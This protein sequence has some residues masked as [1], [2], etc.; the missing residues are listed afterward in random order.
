MPYFFK[1]PKKVRNLEPSFWGSSGVVT[2]GGVD[3]D[4][5]P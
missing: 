3:D 4:M 5:V 1:M 2:V